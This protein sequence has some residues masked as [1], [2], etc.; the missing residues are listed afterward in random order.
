MFRGRYEHTIDKK[1][2]VSVP[3]GFRMEIQRRGEQAPILTNYR[4][5]LALHPADDWAHKERSL[6][7][8]SD[9]Q[10]DV[11]AYQRFVVSGAIECP[12]DSQG[13]ILIPAYLREH[14]GL[15]NKVIIAGVLEKIEIWNPARFEE[16]QKLTLLRLDEIQKSVDRS[17][18]AQGG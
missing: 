1:G 5:H 10:P 14:A 13:R 2:R 7:G 3:S 6:L 8:L 9:L 4:D 16:N 17:P 12:I 11:P 15:E 18:R